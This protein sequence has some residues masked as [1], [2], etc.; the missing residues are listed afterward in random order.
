[1]ILK[2]ILFSLAVV[3]THSQATIEYIT[4]QLVSGSE[5]DTIDLY[6]YSIAIDGEHM[7]IGSAWD[8]GP[9]DAYNREGA[10][11]IFKRENDMWVE[12]EILRPNE[13][14]DSFDSFGEGGLIMRNNLLI[15]G[16]YKD[17]SLAGTIFTYEY[18]GTNW[19][20]DPVHFTPTGV[21]ASDKAGRYL[22]YNPDNTLLVSA[23]SLDRGGQGSV[24]GLFS[25][26]RSGNAWVN[27]TLIQPAIIGTSDFFGTGVS[28]VGNKMTAGATG[29][30]GGGAYGIL[31]T[32]EWTGTEWVE[33][34]TGRIIATNIGSSNGHRFSEISVMS[35]DGNILIVSA[36]GDDFGKI[37]MF[38]WIGNAWVVRSDSPLLPFGVTLDAGDK[39][40]EVMAFKDDILAISARYY[41]SFQGAVFIYHYNSVADEFEQVSYKLATVD[42]DVGVDPISGADFGVALSVDGEFVG[43]GAPRA[44]ISGSNSGG[45][46]VYKASNLPTN[47]PTAAPTPDAGEILSVSSLKLAVTN[48]TK[49][50]DTVNSIISDL[51]VQ[52]PDTADYEFHKRIVAQETGT[53]TLELIQLIGNNTKLK[54][55]FRK[56]RCDDAEDVCGIDFDFNGNRRLLFASRELATS[57]GFE[58]NFDLDSS[59]LGTVN[60]FDF[61]DPEFEQALADALGLN[62]VSDVSVTSIGGDITIEVTLVATPGADPLGD[63]LLDLALELQ[64]NMTSITTALLDELGAEEAQLISSE[65]N[66]CPESRDCNGNGTCDPNTGKCVCVGNWWG[67]N[68]DTA[69]ECENNG[70]CKNALCHCMF[71]YYGLRCSEIRICCE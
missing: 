46:I 24:G 7:A 31:L 26:Q 39:F 21:V 25:Y 58:L 3:A 32:F 5:L 35:D 29:Y 15:I 17:A 23:E 60:G 67:I 37:W 13:Y 41:D 59:L 2:I 56:V 70:E 30:G 4:D 11:Y 12:K 51:N 48:S 66:L 28:I 6:G 50:R 68:C 63:D 33:L 18:N 19:I 16:M 44:D 14:L 62:N 38:D 49:R 42:L 53:L 57:I 1:M 52:F 64:S 47:A 54:E 27:E 22:A 61:D 36:T 8:D 34:T 65:A 45:A 40:G 43:V 55:A 69:C 20:K 10:I 9:G 71:P